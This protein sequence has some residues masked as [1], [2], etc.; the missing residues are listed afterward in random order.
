[1]SNLHETLLATVFYSK[2]PARKFAPLSKN[3]TK[4]KQNKTSRSHSK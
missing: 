1:M 2:R 4:H 3:T